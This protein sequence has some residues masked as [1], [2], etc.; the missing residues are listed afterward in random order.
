MVAIEAVY[1][2]VADAVL[3]RDAMLR[4][5]DQAQADSLP[6]SLELLYNSSVASILADSEMKPVGQVLKLAKSGST[7]SPKNASFYEGTVP[8]VKSGE[9][10]SDDVR[11]ASES[12]SEQALK[13]SSAWLVPEGSTL[14]AMYGQGNTKGKAG[15]VTAP[16][17][18]N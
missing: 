2:R 7:P 8:W 17:A 18:R 12:I 6:R 11:T 13:S 9:V 1:D 15:F 3:C 5:T 4:Q 14:V 16:V 10:E